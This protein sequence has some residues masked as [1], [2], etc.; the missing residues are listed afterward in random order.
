[1]P[2]WTCPSHLS[3]CPTRQHEPSLIDP[4]WSEATC[5]R[6]PLQ[7]L[8]ITRERGQVKCANLFANRFQACRNGESHASCVR[9]RQRYPE[10]LAS[11][12]MSVGSHR[13]WRHGLELG[14][15]G[16][17]PPAG[18]KP[19]TPPASIETRCRHAS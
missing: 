3:R 2:W 13:A 1:M 7:H 5:V 19:E 16:Q 15:V 14:R 8:Q 10:K 11:E 6:P 4:D 18:T 9:R 12:P 17:P